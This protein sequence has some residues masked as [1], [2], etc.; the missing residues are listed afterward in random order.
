ML[1]FDGI[2]RSCVKWKK[3]KGGVLRCDGFEE[4]RKYPTCPGV[5]LKGGGRSQN[6]IRG[7]AKKCASRGTVKPSRRRRAKK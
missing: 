3:A 1:Y 6:Y 2:N 7:G 5:G 4:G